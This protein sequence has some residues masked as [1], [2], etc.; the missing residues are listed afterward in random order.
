MLGNCI[1]PKYLDPGKPLV[2]VVFNGVIIGGALTDSGATMSM[3]TIQTMHKLSLTKLLKR[4]QTVI[5]LTDRS[6][7]V[8]E[9]ILEDIVVTMAAWPVIS[10][11]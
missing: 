11:Y 5:Q 7:T 10:W 3:M 2:D 6:A 4:T 1:M 9:G 8:P